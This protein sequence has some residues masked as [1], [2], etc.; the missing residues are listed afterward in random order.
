V[1]APVVPASGEPIAAILGGCAALRASQP[2]H[3]L[4]YQVVRQIAWCE[5]EGLEEGAQPSGPPRGV[6]EQCAS[7]FEQQNWAALLELC[8]G[9][10]ASGVA[11]AWLDLHRYSYACM[12]QLDRGYEA[13][14]SEMARSVAGLLK[15]Y[16]WLV[17]ATLSDGGPA[18]D[19]ITQ[20]WIDH[21]VGSQPKSVPSG[22]AAGAVAEA[23][24][25]RLD[26]AREVLGSDGLESAIGP[27]QQAAVS[28]RWGR[29]RAC[30]LQ[31]LGTLCLE[32]ERGEL[33]VPVLERLCDELRESGVEDWEGPDFLAGALEALFQ[34]YTLVSN[35]SDEQSERMRDIADE[36]AKVDLGRRLRLD[37]SNL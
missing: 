3:A 10:L 15:R 19:E 28:A 23:G 7:L 29:E 6:R 8:E 22:T 33:A 35:R 18:A 17:E 16:P 9:T 11:G 13:A 21:A 5:L 25:E 1:A 26:R 36:L 4:P 31:D 14:R 27:L 37:E 20:G 32:A 34:S 24:N 30:A 2:F 12:G